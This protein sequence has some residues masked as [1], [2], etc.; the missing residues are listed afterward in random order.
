MQP[1]VGVSLPRELI[2]W[3]LGAPSGPCFWGDFLADEAQ[4]DGYWVHPAVSVSC[5]GKL[6]GWMLDALSGQCFLL[7]QINSVDTGLRPA[8]NAF[9]PGKSLGWIL[10]AAGRRCSSSQKVNWVDIGCTQRSVF[11]G[12]FPC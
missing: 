8:L 7:Q 4:L 5:S 9:F 12:R 2:V 6:L 11:L 10:D 1:A 3:I